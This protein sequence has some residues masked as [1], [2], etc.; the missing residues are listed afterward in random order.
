MSMASKFASVVA[1][2][3]AGSVTLQWAD[4]GDAD[5]HVVITDI[6]PTKLALPGQTTITGSGLLD[7][8]SSSGQFKFDAKVAGVSVLK[9]GGSLCDDKDITLPLNAGSIKFH[10]ISCPVSAGEVS[11]TLDVNLLDSSLASNDLVTIDLSA[12]SDTGEKLLCASLQTNGKTVDAADPYCNE[13]KGCECDCHP[14][15]Y[16]VF[17][18]SDVCA[19]EHRNQVSGQVTDHK[20]C[21]NLATEEVVESP[22]KEA[23]S[24]LCNEGKGCECTCQPDGYYPVFVAADVCACEHRDPYSGQVTDHKNCCNLDEQVV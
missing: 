9:D 7:E 14:G 11:V 17:V 24:P 4:C 8:D 19:C 6:S 18:D 21:C 5:T 22:S 23:V 16:P 20:I 15:Y 12:L 3:S 10:G 13:E 1:V 2:A